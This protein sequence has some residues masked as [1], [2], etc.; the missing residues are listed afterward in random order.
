MGAYAQEG[1]R[2]SGTAADQHA[3]DALLCSGDG[4]CTPTRDGYDMRTQKYCGRIPDALQHHA[5]TSDAKCCTRAVGPGPLHTH[6]RKS[7]SLFMSTPPSGSPDKNES[8]TN[9]D[10]FRDRPRPSSFM[11]R[12][13]SS[14]RATPL[15][16]SPQSPTSQG[17]SLKPAA[18]GSCYTSF[19]GRG[20]QS[21]KDAGEGRGG[22]GGPALTSK[23]SVRDIGPETK[24]SNSVE[25]GDMREGKDKGGERGLGAAGRAGRKSPDP[26][27]FKKTFPH[28]H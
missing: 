18:V 15:P 24:H 22:S 9:V 20:K 2:R 13:S 16:N 25:G 21:G 5:R 27:V 8:R 10:G 12:A 6:T 4:L 28:A 23:A 17:L 3:A 26:G 14:G 19:S 7:R 1:A 11:S